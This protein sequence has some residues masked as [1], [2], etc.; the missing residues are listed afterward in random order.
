LRGSVGV[1]LSGAGGRVEID[2]LAKPGLLG[3]H[4]SKPIVVAH[5]V[6]SSTPSGTLSFSLVLSARAKPALRRHGR[7]ALSARVTLTPAKGSVARLTRTFTLLERLGRS[8]L[9]VQPLGRERP[10]RSF[11]GLRP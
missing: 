8:C 9:S 4:G 1:G 3:A 11:S 5:F 6:R 10:G 7:L 2:L